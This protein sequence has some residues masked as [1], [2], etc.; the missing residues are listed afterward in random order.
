[1]IN[2]L[3]FCSCAQIIVLDQNAIVFTCI[4]CGTILVA[5][6]SILIFF[7]FNR[8]K[9]NELEKE[10]QQL[11][12]KL[13]KQL[14]E[15][16]E[17]QKKNKDVDSTLLNQEKKKTDFVEYCYKMAKSQEEGNEEQRAACW[18]ILLNIHA[19]CLPDDLKQDK[20]EKEEKKKKEFIDHCYKMAKSLEKGNEEQRKE[21]WKILLNI[22]ADCLPDDLLQKYQ[23][24]KKTE[25][26]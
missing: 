22:H 13:S 14:K 9:R 25:S 18:K 11:E 6:A 1:M 7:Y 26:K 23:I 19:D 20:Q 15:L 16:Q 21:C 17:A 3:T 4:I 8:K 12:E 24:Y 10:N 2:L 5:I